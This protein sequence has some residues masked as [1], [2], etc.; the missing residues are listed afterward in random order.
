MFE[1]P[2]C[3]QLHRSGELF[4]QK[5][6]VYL[7]SGGQLR[8]DPL[9]QSELPPTFTKLPRPAEKDPPD[10]ITS[11]QLILSMPASHRQVT[12]PHKDLAVLGRVDPNRGVFPTVDLSPECSSENCVSVSRRHA[13][14][15]QVNKQFFIQDLGST[16]GTFLNGQRLTPYLPRVLNDA[17][18][19]HLG[20]VRVN[21]QIP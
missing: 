17:D 11:K 7:L 4:C 6:G 3:G 18:E 16:N 15:F 1:C 12:L 14:I 19:L 13:H 5:C 2:S 9:P 8:T 10:T 20:N 21:V